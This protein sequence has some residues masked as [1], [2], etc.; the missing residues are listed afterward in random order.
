M[1]QLHV[2]GEQTYKHIRKEFTFADGGTKNLDSVS[3]Q[4]LNKYLS[5]C[6]RP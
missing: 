4:N 3:I 6:I 5:T 2:E 1:R